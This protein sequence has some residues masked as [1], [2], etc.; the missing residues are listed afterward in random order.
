MNPAVLSSSDSVSITF[1]ASFL[2]WIMV[3]GLILLW[4]VDGNK[5][6]EQVL[7]AVLAVVV[8]YS[9]AEIFKSLLPAQRPFIFNDLPPLTITIPK[10]ASFPSSHTAI[11][12]AIAVSVWLHHKKTGLFFMFFAVFVGLGRILGNVH[13]VFDIMAGAVVGTLSAYLIRRLHLFKALKP[14]T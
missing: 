14:H 9:I 3:A 2:I 11:A 7:H 12:F 13:Y 4:L 10:D 1:M 6:K 8:S 5:K